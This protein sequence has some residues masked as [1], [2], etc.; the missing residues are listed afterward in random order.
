M[1]QSKTNLG[2]NLYG[3][4]LKDCT[5]HSDQIFGLQ[6]IAGCAPNSHVDHYKHKPIYI[7]SH[8]FSV[9]L[10]VSRILSD[11]ALAELLGNFTM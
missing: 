6:P 5:N 2:D 4:I 3:A 8:G 9:S 10:T 11:K 7:N 1:L